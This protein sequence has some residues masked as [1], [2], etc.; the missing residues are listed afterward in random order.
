MHT[1]V[2]LLAFLLACAG[3]AILGYGFVMCFTSII[4]CFESEETDDNE[5]DADE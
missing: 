3:I 5:T 1:F 4:N 2:L